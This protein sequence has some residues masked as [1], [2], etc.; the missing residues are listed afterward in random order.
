M[1]GDG[2]AVV[3]RMW[4]AINGSD[5]VDVIMDEVESLLDPEVE[6]VNPDDAIERGTRHGVDGVREALENY[7]AGVGPTAV[8]EIEQ[9]LERGDM[10]YVRGR[11]HARGSASGVEVD[12]PGVGIVHTIRDGRI[13]R[14]EWHWDKEEALARFERAART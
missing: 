11:I 12:G 9:L 3:R 6:Y 4:G 1:A 10:V 7:L 8:F 13:Y 5:S 14:T 2:E